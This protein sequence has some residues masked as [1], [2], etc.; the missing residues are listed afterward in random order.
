MNIWYSLILTGILFLIGL[1]GADNPTIFGV[2]IPYI[3]IGVFILGIVYRVIKWAM[4][5][6]P[7]RWPTTAGQQ[8]SLF[9]HRGWHPCE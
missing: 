8:K 5:P 2:V 9:P 7:F 3:A 6:V 4:S 1:L